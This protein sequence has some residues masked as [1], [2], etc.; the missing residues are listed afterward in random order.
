MMSLPSTVTLPE[1]GE[2]I[3]QIIEIRVVFPAPFGPNNAKISPFLI[4][5]L[6]FFKASKP[7]L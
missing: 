7:E 4:S 5:K 1:V 6:M 2:T 3:P